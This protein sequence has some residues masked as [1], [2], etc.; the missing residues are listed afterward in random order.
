MQVENTFQ[1]EHGGTY[2]TTLTCCSAPWRISSSFVS[3]SKCDRV[4]V[5]DAVLLALRTSR[6]MASEAGKSGQFTFT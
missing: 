1:L 2:R 5:L 4:A 3:E 6:K